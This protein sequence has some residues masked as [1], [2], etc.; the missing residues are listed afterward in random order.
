MLQE[1]VPTTLTLLVAVW[2]NDL[3]SEPLD[4]GTTP[5]AAVATP[6]RSYPRASNF[7]VVRSRRLA[8]GMKPLAPQQARQRA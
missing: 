2:Q 6:L 4:L 1:N 8:M 3:V 5:G 7:W